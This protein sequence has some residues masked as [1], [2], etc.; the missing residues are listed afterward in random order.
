MPQNMRGI[1]SRS[2]LGYILASH[3]KPDSPTAKPGQHHQSSM[4][5][6]NIKIRKLRCHDHPPPAQYLLSFAA[7]YLY[8]DPTRVMTTNQLIHH[9]HFLDDTR[10]HAV[11]QHCSTGRLQH[12]YFPTAACHSRQDVQNKTLEH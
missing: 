5:G 3:V 6:E 1:K 12:E 11:M 7:A 8:R 10:Y 2:R 4:A 9:E